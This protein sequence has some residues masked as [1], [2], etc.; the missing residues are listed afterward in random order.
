[1]VSPPDSSPNMRSAT[2]SGFSGSNEWSMQVGMLFSSTTGVSRTVYVP[3]NL[4]I[5]RKFRKGASIK[6]DP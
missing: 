3:K 6:D 4:P 5:I 2:S 1:M